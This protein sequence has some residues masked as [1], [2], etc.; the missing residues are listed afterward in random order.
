MFRL[1]MLIIQADDL[2]VALTA[3][4][5]GNPFTPELELIVYLLE[6]IIFQVTYIQPQ[7]GILGCNH[8]SFLI[9]LIKDGQLFPLDEFWDIERV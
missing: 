5:K 2:T 1:L 6:N 8:R 9:S 3:C 4:K 7:T